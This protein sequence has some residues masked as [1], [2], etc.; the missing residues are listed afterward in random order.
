MPA[1]RR[2]QR[3]GTGVLHRRNADLSGRVVDLR[4][5]LSGSRRSPPAAH[6]PP[7]GGLKEGRSFEPGHGFVPG[8]QGC[9][10]GM[11]ELFAAEG[12]PGRW[13]E[14]GRVHRDGL[15]AGSGARRVVHDRP[16][17]AVWA[18]AGDEEAN[19]GRRADDPRRVVPPSRV[20]GPA[21]RPPGPVGYPERPGSQSSV[22]AGPDPVSP[23]PGLSRPGPRTPSGTSPR[24]VR[25]RPR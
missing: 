14:E 20:T 15:E 18:G 11:S 4:S 7:S 6:R 24:S 16:L 1:R 10:P 23:T 9:D 2:R 22:A 25:P 17:T 19:P 5:F 21:G 12:G 13:M 3:E 8:H